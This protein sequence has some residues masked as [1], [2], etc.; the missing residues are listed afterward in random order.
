MKSKR[1]FASKKILFLLVCT[2]LILADLG[3]FFILPLETLESHLPAPDYPVDA[4][5][6]LFNDFA[7]SVSGINPETRRRIH[8]GI[9]LLQDGKVE[10]LL[11]TGGNRAWDKNLKGSHLMRKYMSHL[12][13]AKNKILTED[14]SFDTGTNLKLAGKVL[15]GQGLS[16]M[17]L[18]SS[19]YHLKRIQAF[20][21]PQSHDL[22]FSPYSLNTASPPISRSEL[23]YSAHHNLTAYTA[24]MILPDAMYG[25]LIRWIRKNTKF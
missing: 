24:L 11:V 25:S 13:I 16:S 12:G 7:N 19:P 22:H 17:V 4:A 15:Q 21:K 9:K 2:I 10:Y 14:R 3:I 18:V 20:T 5:V 6:V 23:W 1:K 8:H